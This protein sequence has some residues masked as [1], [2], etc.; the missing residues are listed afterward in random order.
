[1]RT[2]TALVTAA[3][4]V[5]LNGM[6]SAADTLTGD[7]GGARAALANSGIELE[8]V[9]KLDLVSNLDDGIKDGARG[10]DNLDVIFSFDGE[11]L[12]GAKGA[13]SQIYILNNNGSQP[14]ADLVGSAQGINNI[15]VAE[16]T[17][18]LYEA[19]IQQNLF[20][21]KLSILGG[22]YDLNSE[23]YLTDS[24]GLFIHPT[25]GIGTDFSQSGLNGPS[26]FPS[27]SLAARVLVR[28]VQGF[29]LQAA[30]LDGAPGAPDDPEGTQIEFNNGEGA[31]FAAE[32]GFIPGNDA[33]NGKLALGAW[34]YSD[35]FPDQ[36]NADAD[37]NPI[38]ERSQG[39]YVIAERK[40]YTQASG[41][42]KG[43][44]IFGR[45]GF[46]DNDVN[47]FDYAWSA[48]LV[49]TGLIPT[50]DA[51]QLGLAVSGAHNSGKFK[52]A[53][54][55]AATP[56]DNAETAYEL[57]YSDNLTPWLALQPDIQYI[58]NPGANPARD[59]ALIVGGR[60]TATF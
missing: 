38:K 31:L 19:W 1:M 7:W 6:A 54:A 2:K 4:G 16:T 33:P 28:P 50:R 23:F 8:A 42:G 51:G 14:D 49:Y 18:K 59:N 12:F 3:C 21:D 9:Y 46:A 11:K 48:G 47:Q 17:T 44:T 26:I 41:E 22:L 10:L 60:I 32:A 15:E 43:L 39:L 35:K 13:S 27:T 29:Y 20:D 36:L 53:N 25:Y 56:V 55:L 58:V 5:F 57:T 45:I 40:I 52:T 30:V 24:S 37:G 34:V